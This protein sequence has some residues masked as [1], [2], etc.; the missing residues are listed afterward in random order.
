MALIDKNLQNVV[1]CTALL[2]LIKNAGSPHQ[3]GPKPEPSDANRGI[4]TGMTGWYSMQRSKCTPV[5]FP[6]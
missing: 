1:Q 5:T 4:I 6:H 2:Q 3:R